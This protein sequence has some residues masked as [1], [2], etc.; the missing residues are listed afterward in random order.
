MIWLCLCLSFPKFKQAAYFLWAF[1]HFCYFSTRLCPTS[2]FSV[3][4]PL[5]CCHYLALEGN[6]S[7]GF[8]QVCSWCV[9]HELD[10]NPTKTVHPHKSL[11]GAEIGRQALCNSAW[12]W[13][14]SHGGT[15]PSLLC[16]TVVSKTAILCHTLNSQPAK[17]STAL[18]LA[19]YC[20]G[21][22]VALDHCNQSQVMLTKI[23]FK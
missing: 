10:E 13:T 9:Q 17:T 16:H 7:P 19:T 12:L 15:S 20:Q 5:V 21:R 2:R 3:S 18:S 11:L 6:P 14:V 4:P 8:P 23:E 1:I 22:L